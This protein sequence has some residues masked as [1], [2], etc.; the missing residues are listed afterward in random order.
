MTESTI[1]AAFAAAGIYPYQPEKAL[2]KIP[3]KN[4]AEC[5]AKLSLHTKLYKIRRDPNSIW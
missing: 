3:V 4:K 5:K 1:K 2:T